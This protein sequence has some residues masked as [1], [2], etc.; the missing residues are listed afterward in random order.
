MFG[1]TVEEA[2]GPAVEIW[3]D[4]IL[5]VRVFIACSTQWRS[6]GF[7]ASGLDYSVLPNVFRMMDIPRKDWAELFEDIRVMEDAALTQM[8]KT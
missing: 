1:M 7:G 8:R 5:A 4:C 3:P 6:S 2:S